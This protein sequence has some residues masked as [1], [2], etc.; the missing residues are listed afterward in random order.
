[1][2]YYGDVFRPPSE[3]GSF[4]LQ[5]TLGCSYNKCRFCGMYKRKQFHI[6]SLEEILADIK[7]VGAIYP[8]L[9]RVFLA[10]GDA[11]AL[12]SDQM[13]SV[14]KT[15]WQTFPRLER[16]SSYATVQNL[17]RKNEKDLKMIREAGLQLLYVGIESGNNEVL[18][19]MNKGTTMESSIRALNRA[20]EAGFGL[21]LTFIGG[22]GGRRLSRVHALDSAAVV[23]AT[24]PEYVSFLT[25]YGAEETMA[26]ELRSGEFEQLNP[27]EVLGE[28]RLF[29]K[30]VDAAGTVFRSN[31]ASNYVSVKGT[32]NKD[33]DAMLG[34]IDSALA[35]RCFRPEGWRGF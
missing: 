26:D 35:N 29:I 8:S 7:E 2:Q 25:L 19:W 32:F 1:M 22:L 34:Q 27:D 4:I 3:A 18:A 15:L 14:L 28:L 16:I 24:K 31:H 21:S 12:P 33:R 5:A 13:L 6:R 9:D 10:D 20:S 30:A 11:L 17:L 23:N